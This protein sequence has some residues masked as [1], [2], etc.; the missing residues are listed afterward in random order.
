MGTGGKILSASLMQ[1]WTNGSCCA[2]VKDTTWVVHRPFATASSTSFFRA[3][4]GK[5]T[6]K[7]VGKEGPK[8]RV[9]RVRASTDV[10][11]GLR[12]D[13]SKRQ[14]FGGSGGSF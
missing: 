14:A 12:A 2:S 9:D 4:Q 8:R 5:W 7:Q 1:A 10:V 13:V 11:G 6:P 3:S